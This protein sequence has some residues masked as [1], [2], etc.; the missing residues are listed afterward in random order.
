MPAASLD[1]SLVALAIIGGLGIGFG[2]VVDVLVAAGNPLFKSQDGINTLGWLR[3]I[4]I[5]GWFLMLLLIVIN[6]L[7]NANSQNDMEV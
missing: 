5:A 3:L 1:G 4:F 7:I 6:H 2:K